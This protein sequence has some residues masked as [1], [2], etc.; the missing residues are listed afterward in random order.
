MSRPAPLEERDLAHEADMREF[1]RENLRNDISA[2]EADDDYDDYAERE[3][4]GDFD[5]V[6]AMSNSEYEAYCETLLD[7]VW[8]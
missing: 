2:E 8:N 5:D 4:R 1:M 7:M 3:A 6:D